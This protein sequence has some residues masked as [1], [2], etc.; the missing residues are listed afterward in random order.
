MPDQTH[1]AGLRSWVDS[2]NGHA[3]YPIQNLPLC[4]HACSGRAPATGVVIGTEILNLS[5]L[6]DSALLSADERRLLAPLSGAT[7]NAY[8]AAPAAQR[9]EIRQL[10]SRLLAQGGETRYRRALES[11]LAP[12]RQCALG[13]PATVGDYT[14]FF[15][16]IH[17][18]MNAGRIFRPNSP[19][20][21]N[22]KY[23]PIAYHGRA[24]SIRASGQPVVRPQGQR[25][26]EGAN[27]P[28]FAPTERLDFELELAVWMGGANSLG[29]PIPISAAG[30]H[31]AGFGLL[32]DWSARDVQQWEAQPL[33]PFLGKNF[34]TSVSPLL[35]TTE[36]LEPFRLPQAPR[37]A[38]DPAPLPYLYDADDQA[39]GALDIHLE[40]HLTTANM[41]RQGVPPFRVTRAT[42]RDLY[43]TP[44]QMVA[45]HT[46]TGCDLRPGDLFGTGTV[47]SPTP[48]GYGSLLERTGG[49]KN[50]FALPG[51][52]QRTYLETGDEVT[53]S[54]WCERA[55]FARI[56]FG[57]V[58]G[59]VLAAIATGDKQ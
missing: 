25:L 12:F 51:G 24:S 2:A 23:V 26:P 16:G 17:H 53:F 54:A 36:A 55:G 41:R 8:M 11:L 42:S 7:L 29:V 15:A 21:P 52:E 9:R 14:D 48:D 20:Q 31:I 3:D 44:A 32:N 6:A 18:A 38:G 40:A 19:L 56:G 37:P 1:D 27:T 57:E 22:Y 10:L 28:E 5:A 59:L 43:W 39:R 49:G 4:S 30:E 50:A 47:S 33:G 58:R 35:V 46:C 34:L 45:H 13:L